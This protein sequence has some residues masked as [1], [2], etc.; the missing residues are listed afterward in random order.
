MSNEV[1]FPNPPWDVSY[2]QMQA[3]LYA[4]ISL[5]HFRADGSLGVLPS[6]GKPAVITNIGSWELVSRQ[7]W[8]GYEFGDNE[9]LVRAGRIVLPFGLR[10]RVPILIPSNRMAWPSPTR[11]KSGAA[12]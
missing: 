1:G 5:G 4:G 7:H 10:K 8:I 2:I 9:F 11:A 6:G 3:D 12:S